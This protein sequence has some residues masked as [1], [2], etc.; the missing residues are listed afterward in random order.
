MTR[1]HL[2]A[3]AVALL[4]M[5]VVLVPPLWVRATGDEVTL[6]IRPVDPLSLL[7][8]NYV[9]LA[10]DVDLPPA[11]RDFDG[12]VYAVFA[13]VRPGRLIR[14]VEQRPDPGPGE[15]CLRGRAEYGRLSFPTLEQFFVTPE[16]GRELERR[17]GE[18]VAVIKVTGGCRAVLTDIQLE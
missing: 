12:V 6:A 14:V 9:D 2:I 18:M 8:G 15:F 11:G 10:Y 17:L 16:R 7:R 1:R 4:A 13:D 5:V 3:I